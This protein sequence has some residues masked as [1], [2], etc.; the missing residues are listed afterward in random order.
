MKDDLIP[1]PPLNR[2]EAEQALANGYLGAEA[3]RLVVL[4]GVAARRHPDVIAKALASVFD[5]KGLEDI[6]RR[7]TASVFR[8]EQQ[9]VEI[10]VL[11]QEIDAEL[12]RI[13]TRIEGLNEWLDRAAARAKAFDRHNR[14]EMK[15]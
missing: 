5:V 12:D 14:Q 15:K 9:A 13:G 1:L 7:T 10:R 4:I 3:D 2:E 8:A 6:V 11:M